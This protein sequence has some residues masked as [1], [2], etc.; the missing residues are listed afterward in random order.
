MRHSGHIVRFSV[1]SVAPR[2]TLQV[3]S[4][5]T[6]NDPKHKL[7]LRFG[8]ARLSFLVSLHYSVVGVFPTL[9]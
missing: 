2:S 8:N 9:I 4:N 5:A 1:D 7:S 3:G 6:D